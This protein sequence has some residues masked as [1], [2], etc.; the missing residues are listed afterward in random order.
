MIKTDV[1]ELK[2]RDYTILF[3]PYT[4]YSLVNLDNGKRYIGRTQNPKERLKQHFR[5]IKSHKHPNKLLNKDSDCQFAFEILEEGITFAYRT[6]KER[7][8]ILLHR[9]YDK[10]LGYNTV[11]PC[12]KNFFGR[13]KKCQKYS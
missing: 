8:Y 4:I 3:A 5:D 12:L 13:S 7:K 10:N 9:T 6:K 1:E 11:D 2:T